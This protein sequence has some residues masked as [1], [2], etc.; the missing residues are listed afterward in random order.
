[1]IQFDVRSWHFKLI[2]YIFGNNF[3]TKEEFD[4]DATIKKI[5]ENSVK[6]LE[7]DKTKSRKEE[8]K[9][10]KDSLVYNQVSKTIN[11]CPYCRAILFGSLMLP[12]VFVWRL[13]PHKKKEPL[14]HQQIMK[15][16]NQRS[17]LIRICAGG[18]NVGLGAP[19]LFSGEEFEMYVGVIQIGIGISIIFMNYIG[20]FLA[21]LI[22]KI[23]KYFEKPEKPQKEKP[24]KNPSLW[25]VYLHT[26]HE[27]ICPVVKFVD[28]NYTSTES[29]E[30]KE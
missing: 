8:D 23:I 21:P 7:W 1:V 24:T 22:V 17:W 2:M 18:I 10:I 15:R 20:N 26:K 29:T 16:M 3:F 13:F 5:D 27:K 30:V 4:M 25:S 28:S 11:F 9:E 6:R 14:T 12:F 19:K